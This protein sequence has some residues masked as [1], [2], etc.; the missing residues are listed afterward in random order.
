M[1]NVLPPYG[2]IMKYSP[3]PDVLV[4]HLA[5]EAVLLDLRD[6]NYYRLNETAARI[7]KEIESGVDR[8]GIIRAVIGE[9]DVTEMEATAEIDRLLS[10]LVERGLIA[11]A[12]AK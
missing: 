10:D 1:H 4:A 5:G 8:A 6:K 11:V 7:W 3:A 12:T 9:F 2:N